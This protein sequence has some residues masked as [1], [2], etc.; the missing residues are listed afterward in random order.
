MRETKA[1]ITAY[2]A[3][4]SLAEAFDNDKDALETAV[5]PRTTDNW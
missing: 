2:G 4:R 1:R 5:D 3:M